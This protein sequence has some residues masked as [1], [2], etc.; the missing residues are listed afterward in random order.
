MGCVTSDSRLDFGGDPDH[1]AD[2]G[3]LKEFLQDRDNRKNLMDQ[4]CLDGGGGCGL[5]MLPFPLL[6]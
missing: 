2:P 6:V 4:N 1:D 3:I 5:Q